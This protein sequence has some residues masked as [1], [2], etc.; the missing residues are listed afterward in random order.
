[1]GGGYGWG[2]SFKIQGS[3][4]KRVPD[5]R[6][7]PKPRWSRLQLA[8]AGAE[9]RQM[10]AQRVS[11]GFWSSKRIQPRTG[12]QKAWVRG[13]VWN[14]V[15]P[16]GLEAL[17]DAVSTADAVAI[18]FRCSA[19]METGASTRFRARA[20]VRKAG[21]F[22][23]KPR[24][25]ERGRSW[26]RRWGRRVWRGYSY[27]YSYSGRWMSWGVGWA[28]CGS[29]TSGKARLVGTLAP[30]EGGRGTAS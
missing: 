13:S 27:S 7:G 10:V 28:V 20:K 23:A 11:D 14:S 30:P 25:E 8:A 15:A 17:R 19:P 22:R 4:L 9:H 5:A 12:G 29:S 16:P 6:E 2:A 3:S 1:M 26:G 24:G 18:F 21:R